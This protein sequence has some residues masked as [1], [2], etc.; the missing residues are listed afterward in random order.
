VM[1]G[2]TGTCYGDGNGGS[3]CS[4]RENENETM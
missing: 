2:A 4:D 3:D 1:R